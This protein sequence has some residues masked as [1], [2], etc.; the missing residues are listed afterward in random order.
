M[1][2]VMTQIHTYPPY[3]LFIPMV[4]L[5]AHRIPSVYLPTY[6]HTNT[7]RIYPRLGLPSCTSSTVLLAHYLLD[8]FFPIFSPAHLSGSCCTEHDCHDHHHHGEPTFPLWLICSAQQQL[9]RDPS[10]S[11]TFDRPDMEPS[12]HFYAHS[13]PKVT[14]KVY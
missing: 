9:N 5:I 2:S 1:Y 7:Y 12:I 6:T 10:P 4:Y 8:E 13:L 11:H 3:I 14:R